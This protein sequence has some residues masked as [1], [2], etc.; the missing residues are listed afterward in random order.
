[1]E[2]R[3]R[4]AGADPSAHRAALATSLNNRKALAAV[5]RSVALYQP[6]ARADPAAHTAALAQA[7][8]TSAALLDRLGRRSR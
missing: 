2:I 1:M 6:L 3:Q 5:E 4:L 7:L 8:V